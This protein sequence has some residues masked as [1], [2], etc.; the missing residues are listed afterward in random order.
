M[1]I[2]WIKAAFTEMR[3]PDFGVPELLK[4]FQAEGFA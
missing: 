2:A 3:R 1:N 4:A